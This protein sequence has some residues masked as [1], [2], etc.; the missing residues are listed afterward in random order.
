MHDIVTGYYVPNAAETAVNIVAGFGATTN[1][2][3]GEQECGQG[4]EDARGQNRIDAYKAWLTYFELPEETTGL[5]CGDQ[6]A[7]IFPDKGS[8]GEGMYAYFEYN[9]D[10]ADGDYA[11]TA[12]DYQTQYS[13]YT[14]DDYKR[15]ICDNIGSGAADCAQAD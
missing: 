15:C 9:E 2:I 11:C 3:N 6:P 14:F 12:V 13:I 4:D 5:T 8:Y 10:L 1:I 7:G